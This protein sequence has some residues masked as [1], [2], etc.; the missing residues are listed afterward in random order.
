VT[1]LDVLSGFEALHICTGYRLPDG[2]LTRRF[3]ASGNLDECEP[4]YE[5][6]P[7]W[8]EDISGVRAVA[9]LPASVH[10]FLE[11]METEVGVPVRTVSV[12]PEREATLP[13]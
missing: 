13:R 3:P 9:E 12:G 7:G 5:P 1:K 6:V 4:M 8:D 10:A 2:S 11:R